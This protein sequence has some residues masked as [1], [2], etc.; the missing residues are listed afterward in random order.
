MLLWAGNC[1]IDG[2]HIGR[3]LSIPSSHAASKLYRAQLSFH[4]VE[5]E[6]CCLGMKPRLKTLKL[7]SMNVKSQ[8]KRI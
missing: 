8:E 6:T 3:Q 4:Q 5:V 2:G 7:C 1:N